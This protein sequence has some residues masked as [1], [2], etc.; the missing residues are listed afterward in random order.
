MV[1][2]PG[3]LLSNTME[4][5]ERGPGTAKEHFGTVFKEHFGRNL[6]KQWRFTL[7]LLYRLVIYDL[8]TTLNMF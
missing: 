5:N 3:P 2:V 8:Q 7:T 4:D 1:A 6:L